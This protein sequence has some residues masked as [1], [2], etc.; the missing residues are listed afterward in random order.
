MRS[1]LRG[2]GA[3]AGRGEEEAALYQ[4]LISAEV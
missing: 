1:A 3:L 4:P 2:P